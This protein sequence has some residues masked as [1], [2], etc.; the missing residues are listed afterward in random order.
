MTCI[1]IY[2]EDKYVYGGSSTS[3]LQ[4]TTSISS[5]PSLSLTILTCLSSLK[6]WAL[7]KKLHANVDFTYEYF[8]HTSRMWF[9]GTICGPHNLLCWTINPP[10][11]A[12]H[13]V[14]HMYSIWHCS[15]TPLKNGAGKGTSFLCGIA[16]IVISKMHWMK[17]MLSF[18]CNSLSYSVSRSRNYY[19][20]TSV[21]WTS[22]F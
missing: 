10:M 21:V 19:C 20:H 12:H 14:Q 8:A 22:K 11:W 2:W 5:L 18:K 7:L 13:L 15:E 17:W 3:S 4:R 1:L 16:H 9:D 6:L